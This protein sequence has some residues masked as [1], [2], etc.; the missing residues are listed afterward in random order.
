MKR[1]FLLKGL[2]A[3]LFC[4]VVTVP[5]HAE[6]EIGILAKRGKKNIEKEWSGLAAYLT[7]QLHERVTF[8]PLEFKEIVTYCENNPDKFIFVNPWFYVRA[9]VKCGARALAT[10]KND[11]SGGMFGGVI[12]SKKGSGIESLR[13]VQGK[14]LICPKFSSAG[15]WLFQKGVL[16][17]AGIKP[18]KDCKSLKEAGTHDS[19]VLAVLKGEAEVGT[20]R[21]NIL[22][23]MQA[24]GKIRIDDF[25]VINPMNY[26]NFPELCST[27]LYPTWPIAALRDVPVSQAQRLK[28]ALLDIPEG[29]QSLS[30][31][32]VDK[33]VDALDYQ[34][35]ENL[36]LALGVQPFR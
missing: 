31:C 26:P 7:D 22:E 6:Y 20:V 24:E 11:K 25:V 35:M 15:G 13:D 1:F 12:F 9:K 14:R 23:R 27:A 29:H 5:S 32:K 2:A 21:T 10:V 8:K 4:L 17:K 16:L 30:M 33:F 28:K 36:L 18:E 19:T 34:P 3:A